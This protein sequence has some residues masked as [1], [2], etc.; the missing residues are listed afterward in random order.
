MRAF[1]TLLLLAL[2]VLPT[3]AQPAS[4]T[5]DARAVG[6]SN[7]SS[8]TYG[9]FTFSANGSANVGIVTD[10]DL[11]GG[12]DRALRW[13]ATFTVAVTEVR[14]AST[15]GTDFDLG[16]LAISRGV[17]E[18]LVDVVGYRDGVERY[19]ASL[20]F[21]QN[22]SDGGASYVG[23]WFGTLTFTGWTVDEVRFR[24]RASRGRLLD[25]DIDDLVVGPS[26]LPVELTAFSA[27]SDGAEV[28][29]RWETASETNN[30]GFEV[31]RHT[32]ADWQ[33]LEFVP[34]HGTTLERTRYQF[35]AAGLAAG[36]HRF[37]LKQIDFDGTVAYS[38][39]VEVSVDLASAPYAVTPVAPSPFAAQASLRFT[40]ARAQPVRADL[41][42]ATGRHVQTLFAGFAEA[43][44]EVPVILDGQALPSGVY[45]VRIEGEGF[46]TTRRALLLK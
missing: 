1:Y 25:L 29:L 38:A 44:R 14:F 22:S 30:A 40:V 42:D 15:D 18:N 19:T 11:A 46:V 32:G 7:A 33:A 13:D 5:F 34:G 16:T 35:Q 43:A 28:L 10:G 24:D 21:D 3:A 8:A 37:R 20:D 36:T 17:G 39:E 12:G 27:V 41:F 26:S 9:D 6:L 31:H 45:F 4:E 2:F 23:Q